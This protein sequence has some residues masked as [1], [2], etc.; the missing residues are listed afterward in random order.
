MI[1][2]YFNYLKLYLSIQQLCCIHA[3]SIAI[4]LNVHFFQSIR[5]IKLI[6]EFLEGWER[7]FYLFPII[8]ALQ[9]PAVFGVKKRDRC[10][11]CRVMRR[12]Y[13]PRSLELKLGQ[14][15]MIPQYDF[16]QKQNPFFC[17]IL[18][19]FC[20]LLIMNYIQII[21]LLYWNLNICMYVVKT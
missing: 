8:P 1:N 16:N 19:W 12:L 3:D 17:I 15:V 9:M 5:F 2:R 4:I 13:S 18:V 7:W 20:L 14:S 21:S 11:L 6:S 10:K